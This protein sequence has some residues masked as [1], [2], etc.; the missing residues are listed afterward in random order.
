MEVNKNIKNTSIQ[1][2]KQNLANSEKYKEDK[3]LVNA[4]LKED[5]KYTE[6]EV[7]DII[8]KYRERILK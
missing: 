7:K 1:Y 6:I 3:D 4:L 2:T 5:K 8:K